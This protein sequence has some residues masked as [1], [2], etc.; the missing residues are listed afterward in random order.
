MNTVYYHSVT[1]SVVFIIGRDWKFR[2]LLRAEL[3]QKG[4]E[5]LGLES[6]DEAGQL[7]ASGTPPRL[8]IFDMNDFE[9]TGDLAHLLALCQSGRL[10]LLVSPGTK[11]PQQLASAATL[12]RPV[13]IGTIAEEI[14]RILSP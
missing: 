8:T 4:L 1:Q 5:A 9:A 12:S 10:L 14:F 2:A 11:L 3:V 7:I 6:L 13:S